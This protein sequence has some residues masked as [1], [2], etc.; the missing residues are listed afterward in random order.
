MTDMKSIFS[1]K[2]PLQ[3]YDYMKI[4]KMTDMKSIFSKNMKTPR[5]ISMYYQ[6]DI[7]SNIQEVFRVKLTSFAI[8]I[9]ALQIKL[10]N[11]ISPQLIVKIIKVV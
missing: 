9:I 4:H 2:L 5:S 1:K 6:G 10:S 7:K 8:N 3:L 11:Y